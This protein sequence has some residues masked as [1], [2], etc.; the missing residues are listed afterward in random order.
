MRGTSAGTNS[1]RK[2]AAF[3][4]PQHTARGGKG[5]MQT[6][7]LAFP[8]GELGELA[9]FSLA[10]PARPQGNLLPSDQAT[11]GGPVAGRRRGPALRSQLAF[12]VDDGAGLTDDAAWG[13]TCTMIGWPAP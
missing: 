10:F 4:A 2:S 11:A 5:G 6:A 13:L 7:G 9:A 3:M 12:F 8:L 1:S